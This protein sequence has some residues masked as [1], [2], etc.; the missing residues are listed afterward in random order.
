MTSGS[1][2]TGLLS[3][4]PEPVRPRDARDVLLAYLAGSLITATTL[5]GWLGWRGLLSW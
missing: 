5:L 3:K 1:L 4:A 2:L